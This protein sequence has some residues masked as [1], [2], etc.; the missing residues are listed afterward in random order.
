MM[1][2]PPRAGG[3]CIYS[4]SGDPA[5]AQFALDPNAPSGWKY[6]HV[7]AALPNEGIVSFWGYESAS[8]LGQQF[9]SQF[10]PVGGDLS[11]S[12]NGWP[13]AA[14]SKGDPI[15][16][17]DYPNS[18]GGPVLI[19]PFD[20]SL[21]EY[22][23]ITVNQ[24]PPGVGLSPAI[25][26][27]PNGN[28]TAAWWN[29]PGNIIMR[30]FDANRNPLTDEVIVNSSTGGSRD[31][32]TLAYNGNNELWIVWDG[33]QSNNYDIYLRHFAADGTP[34][35]AEFKVDRNSFKAIKPFRNWLWHLLGKSQSHGPA[36]TQ[37][38]SGSLPESS[39]P[40]AN[41]LLMNSK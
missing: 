9:D 1:A 16:N 12:V 35:G 6:G 29:A 5:G 40:V 41:P 23:T 18:G 28:F 31:N 11:L 15:L 14:S 33:N 19:I 7:V 38:V 26:A 3:A 22:P 8:I 25:A 2:V 37:A 30:T 21:N 24:N 32:P 20:S 13:A 27:A 10:M 36:L 4:S 39:A 34:I 17:I